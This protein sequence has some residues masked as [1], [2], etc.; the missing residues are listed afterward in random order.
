MVVELLAPPAA[1]IQLIFA[2]QG[3]GILANIFSDAAIDGFYY[4]YSLN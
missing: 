3:A 4:L 2:A 1:W